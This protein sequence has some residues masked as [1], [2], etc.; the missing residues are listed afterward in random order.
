M[1]RQS[2]MF[3]EKQNRKALPLLASVA[4]VLLTFHTACSKKQDPSPRESGEKPSV[5]TP[6]AV[7]INPSKHPHGTVNPNPE[8]LTRDALPATSTVSADTAQP[9]G[10]LV[11]DAPRNPAE[12]AQMLKST[13]DKQAALDAVRHYAANNPHSLG[14]MR[15]LLKSSDSD[16]AMLGAEGL[17]GLGTKEAAAEVIVAIQNAQ[18]GI[19]KRQLTAVLANFS[20]PKAADL[21]MALAGSAQDREL[22]SAIQR[23]L[24]NSANGPVLDEVVRR[25]Q[26]SNSPEERDNLA[27]SIRHM[28]NPVCVEGLIS[29][30]KEQKVVSSTDPLGLAAADTLGIIGSTNAVSYLF[31]HLNNLRTG[32]ISPVY[33][34]IGRVSNPESLPLLASIAYGQVAGSSLYAR[35]SAVQALGNYNSNLAAPALNWLIQNDSNAGIK[36]AARAALRNSA[37]R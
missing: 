24:G 6:T 5:A 33:D 37:G 26:S 2:L 16:V 17:V 34:A 13:R 27:A 10:R 30:L 28:Q 20:N 1:K 11:P 29:I 15:A 4:S 7:A 35:M 32:G 31:G 9:K 36:E 25:Y 14:E 3:I 18:P 19:M 22:A 23:S 21:F 8:L 12:I